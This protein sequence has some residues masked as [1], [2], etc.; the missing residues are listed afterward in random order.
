VRVAYVIGGLG[1][2]GAEYQLV[3]LL[4]HLDRRHVAPTVVSLSADGHWAAA[5]RALG[6]PVVQ[7]PQRH[8]L[9]PRRLWRLRQLLRELRPDVLHTILWSGNSYGRLAALGLGIPV[10]VAAERNVIHRPGW[11]RAMERLLDRSTTAYLTNADAIVDELTGPG[12]LPSAKMH[13]VHNGV[14]LDEFPSFVLDRAP[15]RRRLGFAPDRRL[16]AQVGRLELQKD[17]PTY[18][19]AMALVAEYEPDV[20]FLIVGDGSERAAIEAAVGRAG[21]GDRTRFLGLRHDVPALLTAVDVMVLASRWEGMPNVVIEAM[22]IGAAT[23]A[24]DVG[25]CRTLLGD[26]AGRLVRVGDHAAI[27]AAVRDLLGDRAVREAIAA[28]ARR[29]VEDELS[30]TRMA[31]ETVGLYDRLLAEAGA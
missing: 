15:G 14:D 24:T 13:V 18:V 31:A 10:V 12:G 22:A 29:R 7:I 21:I 26:G 25:A 8:R 6:I 27:A 1:K 30:T 28:R 16:V 17:Y 2:G 3:E 23:V 20:D 4:R 11:Q 5:I 19:A 9:E